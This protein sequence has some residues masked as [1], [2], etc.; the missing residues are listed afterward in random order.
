MIFNEATISE[1]VLLLLLTSNANANAQL[2]S[3]SAGFGEIRLS[4]GLQMANPPLINQA[5][6]VLLTTMPDCQSDAMASVCYWKLSTVTGTLT[7]IWL[8]QIFPWWYWLMGSNSEFK[9]NLMTVYTCQSGLLNSLLNSYDC[10]Y[11]RAKSSPAIYGIQYKGDEDTDHG[12][13]SLTSK[14]EDDSSDQVT[15]SQSLLKIWGVGRVISIAK[16][17]NRFQ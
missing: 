8:H 9:R 14:H 2:F 7:P 10:Q 11:I 6:Y 17:S 5:K 16:Y 1:R 12:N 3:D 4:I 15:D 13:Q